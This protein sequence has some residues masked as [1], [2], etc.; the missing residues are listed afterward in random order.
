LITKRQQLT[1]RFVKDYIVEHSYAPTVTEIADGLGLA[2]RGVVHRYLKALAAAGEI[3]MTPKRHRNIRIV[4]RDPS[5]T[6]Q[7]KGKIAKDRPIEAVFDAAYIDLGSIFIGERRFALRVK[8]N[9]MRE[10]GIS[11]RD[12]IICEQV[13]S[14]RNGQTAVVLIDDAYT[15]IRTWYADHDDMVTLHP[16]NQ[17]QE[18]LRYAINRLQVQGIYMGLVRYGEARP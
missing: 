15:A 13:S 1:L 5:R 2:S 12:L 7:V 18:S 16:V 3:H 4:C 9:F 8:G 6:L 17:Q 11:D 10:Q 14:V